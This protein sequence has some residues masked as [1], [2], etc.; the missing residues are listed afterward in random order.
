MNKQNLIN[1]VKQHTNS[2]EDHPFNG[3]HSHEKIEWTV[4]KQK[5]NSKILALIYVKDHDLQITLKLE[6][7]HGELMRQYQGIEAGYH[8]NKTHWN[9]IHV[10]QTEIS[11]EEIVQMI[12]ESSRLTI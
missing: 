2:F 7:N 1:L 10:N 11:S 8:M 9:T 12:K 6:P 4:M 3:G 5:S